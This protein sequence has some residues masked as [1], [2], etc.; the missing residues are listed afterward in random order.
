MIITFAQTLLKL[1][2]KLPL[3]NTMLL[4]MYIRY[5]YHTFNEFVGLVA[6]MHVRDVHMHKGVI[7]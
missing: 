1:Q 7:L 3:C 5:H 4:T 6:Q 2:D